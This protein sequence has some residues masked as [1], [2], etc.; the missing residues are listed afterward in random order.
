M[1]PT[2]TGQRNKWMKLIQVLPEK[3]IY[4][5]VSQMLSNFSNRNFGYASTNMLNSIF[6]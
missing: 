2:K 1:F 6:L 3:F 4:K 5:H